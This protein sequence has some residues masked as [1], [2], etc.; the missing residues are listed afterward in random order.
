MS[1]DT[2]NQPTNEKLKSSCEWVDHSLEPCV[3]LSRALDD[4]VL[5]D[6]HTLNKETMEERK[7]F[8]SLHSGN[9]KKRGIVINFCPFCQEDISY[10]TGIQNAGR[11]HDGTT[12]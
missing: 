10:Q 11:A 8:V 7:A 1:M 3:F 12:D 6:Q 9:Y 5:Q 2:T 4:K